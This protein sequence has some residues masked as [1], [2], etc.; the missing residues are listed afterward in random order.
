MTFSVL[1]ESEVREKYRRADDKHAMLKILC[2]LTCSTRGDMMRF[3]GLQEAP[4]SKKGKRPA[5]QM[6]KV[7]ARVCYDKGMTDR[8]IAQALGVSRESAACWRKREGLKPNGG[9]QE[10]AERRNALYSLMYHQ[11]Y[12][13]SAIAKAAGVGSAAVGSW[14]KRRGLPPNFKRGHYD[15]TRFK[16]NG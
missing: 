15:R 1:S 6:D 4:E 7:Y 14:R 13:D 11:G 8:Q 12:S 5:K 2:E 3:L 10:T 9:H 16:K